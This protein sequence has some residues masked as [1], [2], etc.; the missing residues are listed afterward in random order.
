M[1]SVSDITTF[2]IS[3]VDAVCENTA[4]KAFHIASNTDFVTL[5]HIIYWVKIDLIPREVFVFK[6]IASCLWTSNPMNQSIVIQVLSVGIAHFNSHCCHTMVVVGSLVYSVSGLFQNCFTSIFVAI[7][8]NG[9][10]LNFD[11]I[12]LIFVCVSFTLSISSRY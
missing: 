5:V 1:A 9:D 12:L 6:N 7:Y 4:L 10:S 11:R 2:C 3:S 8:Y